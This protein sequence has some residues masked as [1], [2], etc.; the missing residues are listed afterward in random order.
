VALEQV[1]SEFELY[2][3]PGKLKISVTY[4]SARDISTKRMSPA[5]LIDQLLNC[6]VHFILS[7]SI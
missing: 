7:H 5:D 6:D 4:I 3:N 1:I 2:Y